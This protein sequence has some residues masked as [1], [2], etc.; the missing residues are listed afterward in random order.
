MLPVVWAWGDSSRAINL[1]LAGNA[2]ANQIA[3]YLYMYVS[4]GT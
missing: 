3:K 2:R 4:A 1:P